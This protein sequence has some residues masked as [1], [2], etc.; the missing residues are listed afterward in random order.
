MSSGNGAIPVVATECVASS[1]LHWAQDSRTQDF[2]GAS[3]GTGLGIATTPGLEFRN[4][5]L[6]SQLVL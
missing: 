6:S 4:S 1:H 3:L 5:Q 2:L